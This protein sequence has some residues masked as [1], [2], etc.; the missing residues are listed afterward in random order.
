MFLSIPFWT[1]SNLLAWRDFCLDSGGGEIMLV[2]WK[3]SLC[4]LQVT[5]ITSGA[6]V[7]DD[8]SVASLHHQ[9]VALLATANG[10]HIAVQVGRE[11]W[12]VPWAREKN[13][14]GREI[15]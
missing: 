7:A 6:V 3:T 11:V 14:E 15:K 10:T 2:S 1:V 9:Q 5:I 13:Q 8:S 4:L 12:E